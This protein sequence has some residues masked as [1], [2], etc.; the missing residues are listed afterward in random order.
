MLHQKMEKKKMKIEKDGLVW[1]LLGWDRCG[2]GHKEFPKG[3]SAPLA[4]PKH[5]QSQST[6]VGDGGRRVRQI[7]HGIVQRFSK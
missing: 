4:Q 1:F 2:R 7:N 5:W 6:A 3:I